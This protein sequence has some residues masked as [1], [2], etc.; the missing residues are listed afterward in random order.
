MLIFVSFFPLN[1]D[2]CFLVTDS[3]K[4]RLI[5]FNPCG[6][7]V[8]RD[9]FTVDYFNALVFRHDI[10]WERN[11]ISLFTCIHGNTCRLCHKGRTL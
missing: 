2:K 8:C 1:D 7:C 4:L 9:I 11:I 5:G 6:D 3:R 10:I